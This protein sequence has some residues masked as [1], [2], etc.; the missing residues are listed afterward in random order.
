MSAPMDAA[1]AAARPGAHWQHEELAASFDERRR[2]LIPLLELQED[3]VARLFSRSEHSVRRFLD[4]GAGAGAMSELMLRAS[5]GS[6]LEGVLVD[7]SQPMLARA[8]VSLAGYPGAGRR[9]Q[10]TST[11][12]PGAMRCPMGAS[13]RSSPGSRSTISRRSAS[14]RCSPRSSS[15]SNPAACS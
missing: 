8:A 3:V 13:T 6:E 11:T 12:A 1:G 7:F 15:C 5:E 10:V 14:P 4:I 9:S 2:I